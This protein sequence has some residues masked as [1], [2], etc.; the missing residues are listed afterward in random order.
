MGEL[1]TAN[2]VQGVSAFTL[3]FKSHYIYNAS[4]FV[5]TNMGWHCQATDSISGFLQVDDLIF[6][7]QIIFNQWEKC[8]LKYP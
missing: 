7:S 5:Y 2:P 8:I 4:L 3:H 1:P 6:T